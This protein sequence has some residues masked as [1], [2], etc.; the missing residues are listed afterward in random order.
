M[1]FVA[2][3]IV[4]AVSL[5]T[6]C[7]NEA[8]HHDARHSDLARFEEL[9]EGTQRAGWKVAPFRQVG[10]LVDTPA[11]S[12]EARVD[13]GDWVPIDI[14]WDE[15]D[16]KV[17]RVVLEEPATTFELRSGEPWS[18]GTVQFFDEVEATDVLARDLPFEEHTTNVAALGPSWVVTRAQW[19]ARNPS[20]VCGSWHRPDRISIHHTTRPD[21]DG[22]DP[23]ARLRQIQAYHI[24]TRGW[25]DIGYHFVVSQSGQ[26]FQ[27]RNESRTGAHVDDH[28]TGNV[29]I[30]FIGNFENQRMGSTQFA[31]GAK[32]LEWVARNYDI[33]LHRRY[34]LGHREQPGQ[35]TD[36]PGR[37]LLP[38]IEELIR[39]A[40]GGGGSVVGPGEVV[41]SPVTFEVNWRS[42]ESDFYRAGSSMDIY[43]AFPGDW[44]RAEVVLKNTTPWPLRG[45]Q[46]GFETDHLIPVDYLI[47]SDAPRF[48]GVSFRTNDANWNPSNPPRT[49]P[50][51]RGTFGLY[52]LAPGETKRITIDLNAGDYSIG[53]VEHAQLR[54]WVRHID[55]YY[56]EQG[57]W[58]EVPVTNVFDGL[59]QASTDIDVVG[60]REWQFDAGETSQTEGWAGCAGASASVDP[61]GGALTFRA[62]AGQCVQSP[63]W[64]S[65]DAADWDRLVLRMD[66]SGNHTAVV[67]WARAGEN[68]DARR[69]GTFEVSPGLRT[70]VLDLAGHPGWSGE[71]TRLRIVPT[72]GGTANASIDALFV[73]SADGYVASSREAYDRSAPVRLGGQVP[74]PIDG[75]VIDGR[76]D[77]LG[78]NVEVDLDDD[79]S[80]T[81]G[82]AS[83][84][85]TPSPFL[86]FLG[87]L[88]AVR[89]RR[90]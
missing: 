51:S 43:D 31:A 40:G 72:I 19:G 58:N 67:Y 89:R 16:H 5:A 88:F 6:G 48:N 32:I 76:A 84:S 65:I 20:R 61:N 78:R 64:T 15:G 37:Y 28:N 36:C 41:A 18:Y 3:F 1:K 33:P 47:E 90:A 82:C 10:V 14:T 9:S 81:G 7:V 8:D 11:T 79:E 42:D 24:D 55:N 83:A 45:V 50:G 23:A 54:A 59:L 75:G 80:P 77:G 86:L 56:G 2:V 17:A 49:N 38:R 22:G 70:Y 30:S 87:L 69:A 21:S 57:D 39:L 62:S 60:R 44:L 71:I 63:R 74:A 34:V 25:C 68:F 73:Q 13:G 52:A 29:G 4:L 46:I 66:V 12:I 35:A 26:V 53:E 85:A 27:G